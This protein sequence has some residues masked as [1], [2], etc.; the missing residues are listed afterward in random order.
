MERPRRKFL[1]R[2]SASATAPA[3]SRACRLSESRDREMVADHAANLSDRRS[4][5]V[6]IAQGLN[7]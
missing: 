4:A 6:Q 1:Q 7:G 2:A 3:F 5:D